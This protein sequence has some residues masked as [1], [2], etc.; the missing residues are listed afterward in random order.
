MSGV[1]ISYARHDQPV[2]KELAQYLQSLGF[3]V[4]WDI[5]LLGADDFNDVIEAELTKARA[6][7]V[8][9]S[10]ASVKSAFVRD[11]ARYALQN[12]KLVATKA[13]INPAAKRRCCINL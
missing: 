4:W 12:G 9:W 5:E 13:T 3:S 6:V 2:A 8:I 1:V 7:I 11:E 10:E